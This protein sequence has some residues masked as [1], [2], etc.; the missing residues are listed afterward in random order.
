MSLLDR[1][2]ER[3]IEASFER[4]LR[5]QTSFEMVLEEI[6]EL[7]M[8]KCTEYGEDRYRQEEWTEEEELWMIFS[9]IYRK[10]IR[11]RQQVANGDQEGMRES[12]LDIASYGAMGV[13]LIDKRRQDS[14]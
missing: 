7:R 6:A 4:Y 12:C 14:V 13:Q 2:R 10:F 11:M 5:H 8:E 3:L 9:D 1:R